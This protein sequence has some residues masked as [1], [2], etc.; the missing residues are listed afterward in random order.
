MF[1]KT[2]AFSLLTWVIKLPTGMFS[3]AFEVR[4][5]LSQNNFAPRA[6][7]RGACWQLHGQRDPLVSLLRGP[8]C[9][10]VSWGAVE[11]DKLREQT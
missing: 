5:V 1:Q 8:W 7:A 3:L 6:K 2:K 10:P 11:M 4:S 9:A